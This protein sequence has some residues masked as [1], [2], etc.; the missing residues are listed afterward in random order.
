M[1]DT[2]AHLYLDS[3]DTD[4]SE[5]IARSLLKL[6]AVINIGIDEKTSRQAVQLAE[7]NDTFYAAVGLHPENVISK[8]STDRVST[9]RVCTHTTWLSELSHH[10][11]VVAIGEIGLDYHEKGEVGSRKLEDGVKEKQKEIFKTQIEIA[12]KNNLPIIVH[13]R[14]AFEDT[15]DI[16]LEY[17]GRICG[18]WHSF[19]EGYKKMQQVLGLGFYIGI[20]GI[21]TYNSAHELQE[22]VSCVDLSHIILE[23]DAPFLPPHPH[24]G[25][26]NEPAM[27][28]LIACKVAELQNRTVD[29]VIAITD[30]NA[31]RIF[32]YY[33]H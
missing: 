31:L 30:V 27:V 25:E 26:R 8:V 17:N 13:S 12:N 15:L 14:D 4:R 18:V 7:S 23:T 3:Y 5:V 19:T 16:L 9:D 33:Q 22:A 1:I 2:H 24:R 28:E 20:N 6:D 10:Q 29:E 11:K 21:V 32:G